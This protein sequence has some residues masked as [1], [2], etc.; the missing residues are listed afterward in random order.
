MKVRK[1]LTISGT[2]CYLNEKNQLHREDGPAM[3]YLDNYKSWYLNGNR[4]NVNSQEEFER[5]LKLIVFK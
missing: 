1:E 2:I 4:I 5:Y 3:E